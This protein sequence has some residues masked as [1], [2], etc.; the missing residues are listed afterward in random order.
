MMSDGLPI[1]SPPQLGVQLNSPRLSRLYRYWLERKGTRRF[2]RRRD[3][4]PLD[5]AYV[6][7]NV[8]LVEVLRDP[9]RFCVRLHGTNMVMRAHY[10]LTGKLIDELPITEYRHYVLERCR[11][12]V[13]SGE[14]IAVRTER[15]LDGRSTR[16]EALWLPFAEDGVRVSML[17]AALIY[18]NEP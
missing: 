15:M 12:L 8:M 6:L 4:D 14:P 5:F 11:G 13:E 7:G 3:I 2:P 10:D 18:H 16:Y 17:M 1:S 9:L